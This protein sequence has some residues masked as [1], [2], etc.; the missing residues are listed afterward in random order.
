[1]TNII[2]H[3]RYYCLSLG[4]IWYGY[5]YLRPTYKPIDHTIIHRFLQILLTQYDLNCAVRVLSVDQCRQL[6]MERILYYFVE[7][8]QVNK[9]E[10]RFYNLKLVELCR[11]KKRIV[12]YR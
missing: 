9:T 10:H 11:K 7:S 6:K 12:T 4:T 2:L 8:L 3:V 1:M 5:L